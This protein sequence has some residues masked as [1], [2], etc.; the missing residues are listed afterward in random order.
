MVNTYCL[1]GVSAPRSQVIN[2]KFSLVNRKYSGWQDT[3]L[4]TNIVTPK[5]LHENR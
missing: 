3:L 4:H 2:L 5:M 1:E